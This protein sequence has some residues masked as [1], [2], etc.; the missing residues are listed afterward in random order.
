MR[1]KDEQ[2]EHIAHKECQYNGT[3]E[4]DDKARVA[5]SL[6]DGMVCRFLLIKLITNLW[7]RVCS[8]G[9]NSSYSSKSKLRRCNF[10]QKINKTVTNFQNYI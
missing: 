3:I 8:M 7:T 4:G 2:Q 9:D 6:C 5:V 1:R 10:F